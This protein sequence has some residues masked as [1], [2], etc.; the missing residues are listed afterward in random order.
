MTAALYLLFRDRAP[1][2]AV[3]AGGARLGMAVLQAVAVLPLLAASALAAP[4]IGRTWLNTWAPVRSA[5]GL[6]A[7]G[8]GSPAAYGASAASRL[9]TSG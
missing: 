7:A 5:L 4:L 9:A 1:I 2:G 6:D 8:A 3:V